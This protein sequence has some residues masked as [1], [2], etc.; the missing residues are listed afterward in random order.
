MDGKC[1]RGFASEGATQMSMVQHGSTKMDIEIV[2][3]TIKNGDFP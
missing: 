2:D 1:T 3:L